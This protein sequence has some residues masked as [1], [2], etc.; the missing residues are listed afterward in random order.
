MRIGIDCR[1]Y[2][3]DSGYAGRYLRAFV[4][5]IDG[6]DDGNE[7]VLFFGERD[8]GEFSPRSG[9]IRTLKTAAKPHSLQEQISFPFELYRAKLDLMLFP[10]PNI[11]VLYNGR[12]VSI[13]FDLVSYFYPEKHLKGSIMRLLRNT[14]L[15]RSIRN[16]AHIIVSGDVL[17]RD[18]IEIFD[19]PEEKIQVIPPMCLSGKKEAS[20]DAKQFLAQ[21][22]IA[23]KYSLSV[24]ELREYKNIP[25]LLQAYNLLI[26]EDAIDMDLVLV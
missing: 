24:G 2:G 3:Q 26:K 13:V 19:T 20:S 11:P 14:L 21:E 7:Y 1:T 15:R 22:N 4:A 10:E 9:R 16:S 25:R 17:K 8:F 6:N 23:E 12:S 18:I 5:H